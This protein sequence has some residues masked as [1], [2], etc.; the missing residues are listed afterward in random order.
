MSRKA[1]MVL[2][3]E[4]QIAPIDKRIPSYSA[5][6]RCSTKEFTVLLSNILE[7]QY[8]KEFISRDIRR[9]MRMD[10]AKM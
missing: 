1:K 9:Q 3:K 2:D 6:P 4:F 10:S 7:E 8:M 5:L